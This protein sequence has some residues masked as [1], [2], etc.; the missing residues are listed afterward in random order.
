MG[1]N[2]WW[3]KKTPDPSP[4]SPEDDGTLG[5]PKY[6]QA[7]R[8]LR[9]IPIKKLFPAVV[10]VSAVVFFAISGVLAWLVLICSFVVKL[11]KTAFKWLRIWP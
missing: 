10:S 2:D 8:T 11:F 6:L 9:D 1:L 3:P 7:W 4:A 5:L